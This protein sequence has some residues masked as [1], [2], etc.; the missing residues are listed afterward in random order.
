MEIT[1]QPHGQ[2]PGVRPVDQV[3]FDMLRS[4][5]AARQAS[6]TT[7]RALSSVQA[8]GTGST[9]SSDSAP[10]ASLTLLTGR[11]QASSGP[12]GGAFADHSGKG[13]PVAKHGEL[14]G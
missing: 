6:T 13:H 8:S 10:V 9:S 3:G 11:R 4:V 7:V 12:M 1:A 5:F 14:H 2:D